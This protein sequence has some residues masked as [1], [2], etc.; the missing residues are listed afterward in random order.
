MASTMAKVIFLAA[1]GGALTGC[2]AD[3]DCTSR[4][5]D[6][7][8]VVKSEA[9]KVFGDTLG[10]NFSLLFGSGERGRL[11][12]A[13]SGMSPDDE[14]VVASASKLLSAAAI[15]WQ[16]DQSSNISMSTPVQDYLPWWKP[17]GS[18]DPRSE[19][20]LEHML[21]QTDGFGESPTFNFSE[22]A[23]AIFTKD[24]ASLATPPKIFTVVPTENYTGKMTFGANQSSPYVWGKTPVED[25]PR[26]GKVFYYE[27]THW[28]MA[29]AA[30]RE[31]SGGKSLEQVTSDLTRH[32][33][34]N[35]SHLEN[36]PSLGG[37]EWIS[38]ASDLEIFLRRVLKRDF[39]KKATQDAFEAAHTK[40]ATWYGFRP[41]PEWGYALGSWSH[42][43][44]G[45]CSQLSSIGLFGTFPVVDFGAPTGGFYF[46]LVRPASVDPKKGVLMDRSIAFWEA[47]QGVL[48]DRVSATQAVV[49]SVLV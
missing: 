49:Q 28:R 30:V 43:P 25:L 16:V 15:L 2:A 46:A 14:V 11:L 26:P 47:L 37:P 6:L 42:C 22:D 3:I 8:G 40:D 24:Y 34:M 29:E 10:G 19:V 13:S 45:T 20:T 33:G 31:I 38:T 1:A 18:A 5:P 27:E 36:I 21:S 23:P 4:L 17:S 48:L 32:F 39:L 44:S 7:C 35:H 12:A 9:L 41:R